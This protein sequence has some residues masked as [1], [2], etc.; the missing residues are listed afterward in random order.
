MVLYVALL[1]G[2]KDSNHNTIISLVGL[3]L[4]NTHRTPIS[5]SRQLQG[6]IPSVVQYARIVHVH[7]GTF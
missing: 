4:G 5:D 2:T 6:Y 1:V 3:S 7:T